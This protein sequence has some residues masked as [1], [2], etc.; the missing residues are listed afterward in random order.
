[1]SPAEPT[2]AEYAACDRKRCFDRRPQAEAVARAHASGRCRRCG[3]GKVY[4]AYECDVCG[5]W[6]TGH[7]DWYVVRALRSER[8]RR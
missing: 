5:Y 7:G 8:R 4:R 6:H 3:E 1:M 2:P